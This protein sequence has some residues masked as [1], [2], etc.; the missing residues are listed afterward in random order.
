MGIERDGVIVAGALFNQFEGFDVHVTIAGT[1]WTKGFATAVGQYV[2]GQLG[3]LRM[4]ATTRHPKVVGYA[5]RLGG[6]VEGRLR[7]HF[8]MGADAIII[9]ILRSEWKLAIVPPDSSAAE[10]LHA[11]PNQGSMNENAKAA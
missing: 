7:N 11:L 10:S 1:G 2:Y 5:E 4:T 6:H 9:G 8:G 3:C